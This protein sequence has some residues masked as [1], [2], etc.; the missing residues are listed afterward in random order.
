MP[1][2]WINNERLRAYRDSLDEH[3]LPVDESLIIGDTFG[4]KNGYLEGKLLLSGHKKPTA[5]FALSHV[6]TLGVLQ[7]FREE[8]LNIPQDV[9]LISFDDLPFSEYFELKVTTVKQPVI[10]MGLMAVNL[11]M[12]QINSPSRKEAVHIKLRTT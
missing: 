3:D 10:E 7:V 4:Q 8:G 1:D 2:S 12:E 9:S 11:L 5:I 6:L